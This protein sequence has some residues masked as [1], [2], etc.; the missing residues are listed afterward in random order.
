MSNLPEPM[1]TKNSNPITGI[2]LEGFQVF[3][4]PTY[5]PLDRLTLLFGPNSAGKSAVQ[6]AIELY[7][8]L[9]SSDMT[10][11]NGY[12]AGELR[13]LLERHW[14]RLGGNDDL[15]VAKLIIGV[16][17]STNCL[18]DM[19]IAGELDREMTFDPDFKCPAELKL[20]SRWHFVRDV[21][22]DTAGEL[23]CDWGFE[24][25][26]ESE[27]IVSYIGTEFRVN[28]GHP[29]LRSIEKKVN[30]EE[31]AIT[32][33]E[34][35]SF[36]DGFFSIKN[37]V[38]G[39]HPTG[40]G[41][42]ENR[43][44]WLS[45]QFPYSQVVTHDKYWKSPLL[46]SA[47]AELGLLVGH[48]L[49][50]SHRNSKFRPSKVDASRQVPTR[51]DLTFEVGHVD[52]AMQRIQPDGDKRYQ[53]LAASLAG[54][55]S[56]EV[57]QKH[58]DNVNRALSGH[59]FL[60]QGYR[61]DYDFRVLMSKA[62]SQAAID[63]SELNPEEFGYLVEM[64]LR[65]GKGRKHL[66]EDVGS[67]IGYVLPVLCALFDPSL[68]PIGTPPTCFIQ[69]PELHIH[70][71]LQAAMGD[72]FIEGSVNKQVLI[73]THSEHL[74]LRILKR[75]RQT[76]LQAAIAPELKINAD[77]VCVLYFNPSPDGTTTVKR[78]RI[79][80]DGEFMDRWPRGFFAERDQELLDE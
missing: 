35:V 78:L 6:D 80:E 37:G 21:E 72:V 15:R 26:V 71:A 38:S 39:F 41:V 53:A 48:L 44:R 12:V 23:S 49:Q 61:L 13:L 40:H 19:A 45:N 30:F 25:F 64:Y 20:E 1:A 3:D 59:L 31:V 36:E 47:L 74:L 42:Y 22:R 29:I 14:R 69:Q 46:L 57:D 11:P 33:P 50:V 79:T 18:V 73:E 52:D 76:H 66:F 65:D 32:H 10:K 55:L 9:L 56:G 43:E 60:E 16:T 4:K 24:F 51:A 67:G 62:N 63:G 27:L 54:N 2:T 75:I 68:L 58:A 5:I 34:E 77:D 17:H 28:L 70:P 7:I 8:K